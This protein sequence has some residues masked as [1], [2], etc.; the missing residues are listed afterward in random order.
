MINHARSLL[1]NVDGS[2]SGFSGQPGAEFIPPD[3]RSQTLPSF[4]LTIREVL[5]GPNPDRTMLNYRARQLMTLLHITELEEFI[6]ELDSRLTYPLAPLDDFFNNLFVTTVTPLGGTT[7]E[8]FIHGAIPAA[9]A[10][11]RVEQQWTVEVT[12]GSNADVTRHTAPTSVTSTSYTLT[13]GL[14]SKVALPG[15]DLSVKFNTGV[16]SQ[17]YVTSAARPGTD[18][19]TL[20]ANIDSITEDVKLELF[21]VGS[22][23]GASEPFKTFRNLYN[24]HTELPYRLGGILLAL[25]LQTERLRVENA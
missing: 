6:T 7:N 15:S 17:W 23:L 1:L 19:G 18:L 20:L 14:S 25:I 11:G 13:S 24:M 12:T 9:D 22:A 3:Y 10:N 4:L 16:G 2:G 8:L 21:S 5:F